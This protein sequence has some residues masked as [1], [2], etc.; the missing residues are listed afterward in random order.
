MTN[1]AQF[2]FDHR[3]GKY[4]L[5]Y[6]I[7]VATSGSTFDIL[8][9]NRILIIVGWKKETGNWNTWMKGDIRNYSII[10]NIPANPFKINIIYICELLSVFMTVFRLRRASVPCTSTKISLQ[11][12]RNIPLKRDACIWCLQCIDIL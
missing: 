9:D 7:S 4:Y 11:E 6:F 8:T 12:K 10:I 5:H 1:Y 3:L 2:D